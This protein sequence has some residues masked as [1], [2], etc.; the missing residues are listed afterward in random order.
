MGVR[1]KTE[2]PTS[3]QQCCGRVDSVT[4]V[5]LG[6]RT[7]AYARFGA[8]EIS[9][10]LVGEVGGVHGKTPVDLPGLLRRVNVWRRLVGSGP[11]DAGGHMP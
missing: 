6:G 7:E 3:D 8:V 5:A 11:V 2:Q 1:T 9:Q 4:T 10:V